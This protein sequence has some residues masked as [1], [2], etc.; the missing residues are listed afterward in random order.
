MMPL[1]AA[2]RLSDYGCVVDLVYGRRATALIEAAR[3][4]SV[5]VVDGLELLIAQGALSFRNFTGI[6]APREAMRVAVRTDA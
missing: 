4:R 5:P 2:E 1:I 6:D 3:E